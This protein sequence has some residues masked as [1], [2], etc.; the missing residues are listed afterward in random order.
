MNY[1]P[2]IFKMIKSKMQTN[3]LKRILTKVKFNNDSEHEVKR[4]KKGRTMSSAYIYLTVPHLI[5]VASEKLTYI[6]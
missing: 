1:I 4:L 5:L 6:K 2:S 3:I